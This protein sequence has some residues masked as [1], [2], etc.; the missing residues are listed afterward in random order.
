MSVYR[1]TLPGC[2]I[3][4][5]FT[6]DPSYEAID[7]EITAWK[8]GMRHSSD[9]LNCPMA[10]CEDCPLYHFDVDIDCHTAL[11]SLIPFRLHSTIY[12]RSPRS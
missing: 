7:Y 3:P 4:I 2:T 10:A 1:T 8:P 11:L 12:Q 5:V 6:D 9:S